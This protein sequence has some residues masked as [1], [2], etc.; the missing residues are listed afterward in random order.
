MVAIQK[1][2]RQA[3][4]L[5]F[6]RDCDQDQAAFLALSVGELIDRINDTPGNDHEL[7]VETIPVVLTQDPVFVSEGLRI[8]AR[9]ASDIIGS[10]TTR[11]TNAERVTSHHIVL[12]L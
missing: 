7:E 4:Y 1:D 6:P 3:S 10:L 9:G 5:R 11:A 2:F 8:D 12:D